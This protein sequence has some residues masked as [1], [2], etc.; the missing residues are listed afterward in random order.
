MDEISESPCEMHQAAAHFIL[1]P[2]VPIMYKLKYFA[3]T[4]TMVGLQICAIYAMLS[5]VDDMASTDVLSSFMD[6]HTMDWWMHICLSFLIG[7]AAHAELEQS[8][9]CDMQLYN[10]VTS[11]DPA[12]AASAGRW[13]P[14]LVVIH[15]LRQLVLLPLTLATAPIMA[16]EGGLN[17]EDVALNVMAILFIL[18]LDDGAFH[19]LC[20]R[21]Q[22][23]YLEGVT[24]PLGGREQGRL[25]WLTG[26][27]ALVTF[28][29]SLLPILLYDPNAIFGANDRDDKFAGFF[30]ASDGGPGGEPV[31]TL[32]LLSTI[33]FCVLTALELG[34]KVGCDGV[35]R[36][37]TRG[38]NLFLWELVVA[39][40]IAAFTF[41]LGTA[42][43][44][45]VA[46]TGGATVSSSNSGNATR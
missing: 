18:E 28:G 36:N 46:A 38:R 34:Y 9:V 25:A 1:H 3:I 8:Q 26:G 37:D 40:G 39:I 6:M 29:S 45:A 21:A 14:L 35:C 4:S 19:S 22:R 31:R 7:F 5:A 43:G 13:A 23:A 15:K 16:I 10:S 33:F 12:V 11:D 24:I 20:S 44:V 30:Q 42:A 41:Y 17:A 2:Q 32:M 27:V